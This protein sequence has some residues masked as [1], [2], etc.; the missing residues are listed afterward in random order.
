MKIKVVNDKLPYFNENCEVIKLNYDTVIA[1]MQEEKICLNMSDVQFIPEN[2]YES[3][4][5]SNKDILKI[6]LN[7]GMSIFFYL[8]LITALEDKVGQKLV[9]IVLIRDKFRD[10][11]KGVW[12][13]QITLVVNDQSPFDIFVFG[14]KYS[15]TFDITIKEIILEDFIN[16]CHKEIRNL[17]EEILEKEENIKIYKKVLKNVLDNSIKKHKSSIKMI[18]G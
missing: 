2:T 13:K 4:L 8:A 9:S 14:K 11:R 10:T 17:K 5:L 16:G 1:R 18:E 6:K 3:L 12:E 15:R 7:S